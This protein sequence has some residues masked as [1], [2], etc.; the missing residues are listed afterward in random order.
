VSQLSFA[1]LDCL[2][3]KKQTK[4]E[5]FVAGVLARI[6]AGIQH[7]NSTNC[8]RGTGVLREQPTTG[9][10][11]QTTIMDSTLIT[12]SPST[13]NQ[14]GKRDSEMS[15]SQ[16]GNQWYFG[17]KAHVVDARSGLVHAAGVST[18]CSAAA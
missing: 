15:Q 10:R 18:G 2:G 3:R 5:R 6:A 7:R 1:T 11:G 8:C 12:A 4:R 14:S 9:D 17:M 13:K 16:K